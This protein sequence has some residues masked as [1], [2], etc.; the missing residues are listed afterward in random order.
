MSCVLGS[1]SESELEHENETM[2]IFSFICLLCGS[3]LV[4]YFVVVS[5]FKY[6]PESV[7]VVIY[8]ILVGTVL[9]F[10]NAPVAVHL[11]TFDPE[12]FFL[13]ILPCIIFETGFSIP[14]VGQ[15]ISQLCLTYP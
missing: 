4:V 13:F 8:G 9:K 10:I 7:A 5:K 6:L 14:K 11:K 3:V 1:S 12:A 2:L 15:I